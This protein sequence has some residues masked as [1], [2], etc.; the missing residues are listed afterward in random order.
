MGLFLSTE[1][2]LDIE[3]LSDIKKIEDALDS[4]FDINSTKLKSNYIIYLNR[5][6]LHYA[7]DKNNIYLFNLLMHYRPDIN[8][9]DIYGQTPF[10]ILCIKSLRYDINMYMIDQLLRDYPSKL[11][12][13]LDENKMPA[14]TYAS[15]YLKLYLIDKGLNSQN[16]KWSQEHIARLSELIDKNPTKTFHEIAEKELKNVYCSGCNILY[17]MKFDKCAKC[18]KQENIDKIDK[19]IQKK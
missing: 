1:R 13:T 8:V 2:Y 17:M 7:C 3:D 9:Q 6:L 14:I 15:W 12:D 10:H 16:D 19:F 18:H 5:T 4:W 11:F